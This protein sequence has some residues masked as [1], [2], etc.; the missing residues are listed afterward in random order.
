MKTAAARPRLVLV[1]E[2]SA[3]IPS[4][5]IANRFPMLN[6]P[7]TNGRCAENLHTRRYGAI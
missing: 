2:S 1:R 4:A 3:H 6:P 7:S 5:V